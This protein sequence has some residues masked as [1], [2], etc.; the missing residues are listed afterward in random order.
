MM[1]GLLSCGG[2][3]DTSGVETTMSAPTE[4]AQVDLPDT[5]RASD[6]DQ[7]VAVV[8]GGRF[9]LLLPAD[10]TRGWRWVLEPVDTAMVVPLSS[11]FLDDPA[12][13]ASTSSTTSTTISTGSSTDTTEPAVTWV[14][15]TTTTI[16]PQSPEAAPLVQ[17]ISFAARAPGTTTIRLRYE[18]LGGSDRTPRRVTFTIVVGAGQS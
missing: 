14:P 1:L 13:L 5:I 6:P 2:S 18:R 16:D 8:L 9:E 10:P 11:E 3:S 12:L 17:V 4:S 15:T 7:P